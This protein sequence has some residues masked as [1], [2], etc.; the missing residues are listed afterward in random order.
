MDAEG[1]EHGKLA[2]RLRPINVDHHLDAIARRHRDVFVADD[3]LVL[4]RPPVVGRRL[5]AG[6]KELLR[7][8]GLIVFHLYLNLAAR[9][10]IC[11][12][13]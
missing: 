10:F 2:H 7:G 3:P 9:A 13:P 5:M 1:E 12:R 11:H 4:R 8:A 6:R